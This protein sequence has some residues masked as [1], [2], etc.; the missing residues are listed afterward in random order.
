MPANARMSEDH[1]KYYIKTPQEMSRYEIAELERELRELD[2]PDEFAA[3]G[4]DGLEDEEERLAAIKDDPEFIEY[5]RQLR[6]L[7]PIRHAA[8]KRYFDKYKMAKQAREDLL[9][10]A[11]QSEGFV[12]SMMGKEYVHFTEAIP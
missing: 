11:E 1:S 4:G 6:N 8:I 9:A 7:I 2:E 5:Q 3:E 12:R 10:A